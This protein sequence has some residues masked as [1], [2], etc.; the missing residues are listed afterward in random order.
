MHFVVSTLCFAVG[1]MRDVCPGDDGK[2]L[3]VIDAAGGTVTMPRGATDGWLWRAAFEVP[4]SCITLARTPA[5]FDVELPAQS[6]AST[7]QASTLK[8]PPPCWSS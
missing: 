7:R 5:D 6:W 2:G 8:E 1:F 4:S 3:C